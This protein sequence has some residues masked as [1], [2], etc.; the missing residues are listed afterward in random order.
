MM[1]IGQCFV[2][3][4]SFTLIFSACSSDKEKRIEVPSIPMHDST[5]EKPWEKSADHVKNNKI[6]SCKDLFE[7][8]SYYERYANEPIWESILSSKLFRSIIEIP[9]TKE[10]VSKDFFITGNSWKES[11]IKGAYHFSLDY[12]P[13]MNYDSISYS[14]QIIT[15]SNCNILR[16]SMLKWVNHGLGRSKF[17]DFYCKSDSI[18]ELYTNGWQKTADGDSKKNYLELKREF[19]S[20]K[21]QR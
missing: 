16:Y 10:N 14:V 12:L 21:K 1:K 11:R 2:T 3:A 19:M 9:V 20:G 6:S 15:D 7:E 18:E 8:L 4:L 13:E 5:L 17:I